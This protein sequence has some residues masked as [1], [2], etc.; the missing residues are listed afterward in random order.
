M[1][2]CAGSACVDVRTLAEHRAL[3]MSRFENLLMKN[4]TV[5]LPHEDAVT[6]AVNAAQPLVAALTA[7]ERE[8]IELLIT[9]S[10]SGIDFSKSLSTYVHQHLELN[11]NCRLLEIKQACYSGT[12]GLQMAASVV[13]SQVSPGCKALVV[14]TDVSRFAAAEGKDARGEGISFAEPSTGAGAV[15]LIVSDDP[16]VFRMD[17]GANGYYGYEVMDTC[18][19][20][21]DAD[22]GDADL[23]LLSYLDC[24]EKTF[25]EYQQ[26]VADVTYEGTFEYLAFHA[27]FG[28]MV[29]GAHRT[30][31]RKRTKAN[32]QVIEA[33]F[34][35][36]VAP[37]LIYCQ[38]VGNIM[39]ATVLLSL[40]S[41]I[42]HGEFHTP[43][44]VGC[45]SYGSGCCSEFYSG[46]VEPES[47]QL[48][49]GS[50]I[51]SGLENR[52]ALSMRE[53]DRVREASTAVKFGTRNVDVDRGI[54]PQ[55]RQ[56]GTARPQLT[57]RR[58]R[59]YHREY[60]WVT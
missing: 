9:C 12:A 51:A 49:R 18:R 28:G 50:Q 40:A 22:A 31:M 29:K 11:R 6:F 45:F 1:N 32:P 25:Q 26:R 38:Q 27:P 37:G 19:P 16:R 20:V 53:Y 8:R 42:D 14:A 47:Q 36:R 54:A 43:K 5:P 41:T 52:V 59:E 4:R 33:D 58:I 15:A 21:A 13:L 48:L 7:A 60:E 2:V 23:S 10:E 3:D 35:R 44:R 57:L 46:V 34:Q 56:G 30:M 17:V 55:A 39:G 24:C